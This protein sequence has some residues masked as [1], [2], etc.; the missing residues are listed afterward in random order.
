M[1]GK[2][3]AWCTHANFLLEI[4]K[5][6]LYHHLSFWFALLLLLL[7]LLT[8]HLSSSQL[9]KNYSKK[10][11]SKTK[12]LIEKR[13]RWGVEAWR[14]GLDTLTLA[15]E[16]GWPSYVGQGIIWITLKANFKKDEPIL[17]V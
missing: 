17:E 8:N 3:H 11:E 1:D 13:R 9:L 10:D 14:G 16:S 7:L 15:F 6:P 12:I 5:L 4:P 2:L